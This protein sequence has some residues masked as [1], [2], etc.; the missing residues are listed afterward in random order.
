MLQNWNYGR[1]IALA[2]DEFASTCKF[3]LMRWRSSVCDSS[4]AA[5]VT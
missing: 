4:V 5:E 1:A 2:C 3:Q